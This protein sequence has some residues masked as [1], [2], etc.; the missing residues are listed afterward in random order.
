[1][2]AS[3][4][5]LAVQLIGWILGKNAEATEAKKKFLEFVS[6]LGKDSLVSK[7]MKDDYDKQLEELK[8]S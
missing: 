8:K 3:I 4:L 1:M 2:W 5:T 6:Q 7:K